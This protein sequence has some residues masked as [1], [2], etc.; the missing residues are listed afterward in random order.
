MQ[1]RVPPM[2]VA[3][4]A[5]ALVLSTARQAGATEPSADPVRVLAL[6]DVP[7]QPEGTLT[8]QQADQ[9]RKAITETVRDLRKELK[10][11]DVEDF[12]RFQ[13]VP[14]VAL[15]V[16]PEDLDQVTAS[17]EVAAVQE[18]AALRTMLAESTSR[19]EAPGA[20]ATG[21]TGSGQTVAIL[22][23]GVEAAHPFLGSRVVEEACYS[24]GKDCPNGNAVQIGPGS[25]RPCTYAADCAHGT[26]VA[27]I[28]AGSGTFSG[29]A[30]GAKVM[31]VQVFSEASG[32]SL[33]GYPGTCALAM[34]SDLIKAMER[35]YALRTVHSFAAVNLSLG[36][37]SFAGSC[38]T[39]PMKPIIDNLRTAGIATVVAS[40]NAGNP[41]ALSAPACISTAVSVGATTDGSPEEVAAYSNSS[42]AL[43]VLA[44]GS[45][46]TSSV[47]G[48]GFA[49]WDG[50]SMAAPHVAGAWA[51]LKAAN[52]AAAVPTVLSNLQATGQPITDGRNGRTTPRIRV[53]G[54]LTGQGWTPPPTAPATHPRHVTLRLSRHLKALGDVTVPDGTPACLTG[55]VAIER[56]AG[57]RWKKVKSASTAQDGSYKVRL[58]DHPGRYRAAVLFTSEC[59]A[60]VS[61]PRTY[62]Q[63]SPSR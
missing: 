3:A 16:A 61:R 18:D 2:L 22:D 32:V 19:I 63:R 40:G 4:L 27:G 36:W 28:A 59:E 29:V 20:W 23:T 17:P 37:G 12:D 55:R 15:E 51:V 8:G 46:I 35:V 21:A 6:L 26:H 58:P 60:D 62:R 10:E 11:A 48:G 39:D 5:A 38:D 25:A 30:P 53:H 52:P 7:F 13:T 33:C 1:P 54:A 31:A 24:A 41:G 57:K 34:T 49:T 45:S 43:S 50:T 44:A 14:F 42:P 9:Q 56:K 47:P